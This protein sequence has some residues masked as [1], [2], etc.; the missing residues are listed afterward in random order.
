MR[1]TAGIFLSV[2]V[3]SSLAG[4]ATAV[5]LNDANEQ[6]SSHYAAQVQAAGDPVMKE[7]A[8]AALRDLGKVTADRAAKE[9]DPLNKISFYRIAATA[10]WKAGDNNVVQYVA[11]GSAV[12]ENHW[13][14]APRDCG[15]LVMIDD[16]AAIDETTAKF[17]RLR[18]EGPTA[19]GVAEIVKTYDSIAGGMIDGRAPLV[20][21]V[22]AALLAEYDVRL[23]DL[24][25]KL[26]RG[27]AVGLA[28][29]VSAPVN[30][31]CRLG[32]LRLKA[33]AAGVELPTCAEPMPAAVVE[34]CD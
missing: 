5:Q 1:N 17:N 32:N 14:I 28:V 16:L 30:A 22:P 11:A 31:E 13:N 34:N 18:A 29:T 8:T 6:L 2:V 9:S 4:C 10:A 12:C 19:D 7:T 27:G 33:D 20:D 15:M 21:S 26:F 3:W 25:C 23:D 24:I